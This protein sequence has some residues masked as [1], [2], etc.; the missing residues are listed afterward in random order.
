MM[1]RR[2]RPIRIE[3]DY[4]FVALS[5][6]Y[7][8][9]IDYEDIDKVQGWNWSA[10]VHRS[11]RVYALRGITVPGK[12]RAVFM[13][14]I[15]AGD[16]DRSLDVDHINGNTLDNRRQN[17]RPATRAQNSW[18]SRLRSNN[19]SGRRGVSFCKMTGRWSA[20]IRSNGKGPKRLG[21]FAT[22]EEAA[23]AYEAAALEQRG[24]EF[25]PRHSVEH[26]GPLFALPEAAE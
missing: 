6:G 20:L 24:T 11:G 10:A 18:N 21:R 1:P 15:I 2:L 12:P 17:L 5:R 4:A 22:V 19:T 9:I 23:A 16:P 14:R 3:A 8:A 13:H 26:A 25:T 7:V